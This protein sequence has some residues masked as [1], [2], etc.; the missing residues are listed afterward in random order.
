MRLVCKQ[1]VERPICTVT[2]CPSCME[3][4]A[5]AHGAKRPQRVNEDQRRQDARRWV[6]FRGS[7]ENPPNI[8]RAVCVPLPLPYMD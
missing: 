1:H 7:G 5:R 6:K 8:L 3:L 2:L 4:R